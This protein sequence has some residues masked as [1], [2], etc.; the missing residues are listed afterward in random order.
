MLNQMED[1]YLRAC[2]DCAATCLR[3]A[4]DCGKHEVDYFQHC[5]ETCERYAVA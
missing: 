4:A 1:E 3:C 2:N 5:S